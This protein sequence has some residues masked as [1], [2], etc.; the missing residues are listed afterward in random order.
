SGPVVSRLDSFGEAAYQLDPHLS[1]SVRQPL[2]KALMNGKWEALAD[3]HNLLA[4]GYVPANGR[5][6]R[7][8]LVPAFRS[9]RGVGR[10][11]LE[12]GLP[13]SNTTGRLPSIR[14]TALHQPS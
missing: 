1:L 13:T 14:R 12:V 3:F 4:Q 5:D 6:G 8:L 11:Q 9:F 7:V 10:F 2:P